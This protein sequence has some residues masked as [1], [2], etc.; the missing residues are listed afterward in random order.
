MKKLVLLSAALLMIA[1]AAF[2]QMVFRTQ[3]DGESFMI[4]EVG[5]LLLDEDGKVNVRFVMPEARR[6]E[7]YKNVDIKQDD[8]VLYL[9]GVR[10][11]KVETFKAKYDSLKFGEEVQ[12]G[13]RRDKNRFIASFMKADPKDLPETGMTMVRR[14]G[15]GEGE[16]SGATTTSGGGERRMTM[17]GS[18]LMQEAEAIKP[19]VELALL[20]GKIEDQAVVVGKLPIPGA[21]DKMEFEEEDVLASVNGDKVKSYDHF[22]ELWEKIKLGDE[23][24]LKVTRDKKD[25]SG[26]FAKPAPPAGINIKTR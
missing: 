6:G 21:F 22:F 10:I 16:T 9:N 26:K 14:G 1:P 3:G 13:L 5:A 19:L 24:T 4:P 12:I 25:V 18:P 11:K 2:G 15:A 8:I 17:Q 23:V 20:I 7:K